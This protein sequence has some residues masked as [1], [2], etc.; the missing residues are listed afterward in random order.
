MIDTCSQISS[1]VWKQDLERV[2][3]IIYQIYNNDGLPQGL[4]IRKYQQNP[5]KFFE[6]ACVIIGLLIFGYA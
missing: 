5:T 1:Q 6:Y 2:S 4:T 3:Q